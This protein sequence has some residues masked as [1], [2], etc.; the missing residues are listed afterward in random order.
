MQPTP[1]DILKKYWGYDE[2][3]FNQADIINSV[4]Q[5]QDTIAIL[6]TGGGKSICFQVP[7][8]L[9]P[10]ITVVV[11]PLISLMQDQVENLHAKKVSA[12]FLNSTLTKTLKKKRYR[13]IGQGKYKL[14]YLAP[15]SL[16]VPSI[17]KL[18]SALPISLVVID[19]AHCISIWGKDFRPSYLAIN[20]F[21][22]SLPL[23][24]TVTSY[25]SHSH[26]KN[27]Q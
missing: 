1:T 14:V 3:R 7:S 8:L 26:K 22:D 24:P 25:H 23:R 10:G 2:F 9:F 17:Q 20:Q 27:P 21:V 4:V 11:S 6:P 19:E 18:L 12:T 5:K 16:Q 15:E 13:A